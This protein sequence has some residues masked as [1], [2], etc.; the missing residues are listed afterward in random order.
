[1]LTQRNH[2]NPFVFDE[3][4]FANLTTLTF[5]G[6]PLYYVHAINNILPPIVGLFLAFLFYYLFRYRTPLQFRPYT[7]IFTL[8]IGVDLFVIAVNLIFQS[9]SFLILFA[10]SLLFL[11]H[12]NNKWC[13]FTDNRRTNL[14]LSLPN[15]MLTA[16]CSRCC[17]G[18][19]SC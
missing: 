6:T 15:K 18:D 9:V 7:K 8:A 11:A 12:P 16:I 14:L 13:Y 5:E 1:M 19:W 4:H 2:D 10:L 17:M 3:L